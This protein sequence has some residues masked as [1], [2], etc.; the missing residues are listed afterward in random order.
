MV[1][2]MTIGVVVDDTVHFLGKYRR[3]RLEHGLG[4]ED[5]VRY[6]FRAAGRAMVTTTIVLVAGFLVLLLSDFIPTAEVGLLTAYI[7][8]FALIADFLLLPPLLMAV[9]RRADSTAT[10]SA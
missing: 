3:A 7:I 8:A 10:A 2:A 5:A 1:V 4:S 9:D 6:A